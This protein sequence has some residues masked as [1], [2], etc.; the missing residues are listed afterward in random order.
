MCFVWNPHKGQGVTKGL[1]V[2]AFKEGEIE[3]RGMMNQKG[4]LE[5]EG[6]NW[7]GAKAR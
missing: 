2:A 7:G 1:C 3:C 4:I 5:Q 6:L